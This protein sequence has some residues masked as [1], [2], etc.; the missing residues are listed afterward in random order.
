MGSSRST[1]ATGRAAMS[2]VPILDGSPAAV[3]E[4]HRHEAGNGDG[5]KKLPEHRLQVGHTAGEWIDR[6]DVPVARGGQRGEAEIQHDR[7]F[8]RVALRGNEI[9]EGVWAQ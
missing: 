3:C 1:I 6:D 7:D 9:D 8:F 4:F 2:M 5:E